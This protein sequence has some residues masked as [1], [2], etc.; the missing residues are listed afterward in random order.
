MKEEILYTPEEI[1]KKLKLS[2]YTIYEMIKRGELP[3]HRLGRSL[4]ITESQLHTYLSQSK[5]SE[6]S[7]EADIVMKD[8]EK[9]AKIIGSVGDLYI[10]VSTDAEG[11][12][13]VSIKPES[14]ILSMTPLACSALNNISGTV[15]G[16]EEQNN[17]YRITLNIGVPL[18][19]NA[20]KR[21]IDE[22]GFK[23]GDSIYAVFK[24]V[25]VTVV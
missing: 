10:A 3:A 20:S 21:A 11:F 13:K 7:Y 22:M 9:T 1:A 15:A 18:I 17:S 16:M 2:K 8:G 19:V 5:K 6:N 12:A 25:A 23:L 4:R 14:I 24:A